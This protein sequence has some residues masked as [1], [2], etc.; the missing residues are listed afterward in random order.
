MRSTSFRSAWLNEVGNCFFKE[1]APGVPPKKA[2]QMS[3]LTYNGT[4]QIATPPAVKVGTTCKAYRDDR[5][6]WTNWAITFLRNRSSSF[7]PKKQFCTPKNLIH[8][9]WKES[10]RNTFPHTSAG[11]SPAPFLHVSSITL[12]PALGGA[13]RASFLF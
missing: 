8:L 4:F 12:I 2:P 5:L 7:P 11:R 6:G 9:Q 1:I 13:Q 10:H 3:P